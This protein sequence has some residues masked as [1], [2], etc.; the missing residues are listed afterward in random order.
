MNTWGNTGSS[1]PAT[2]DRALWY[3]MGALLT[4]G[5][6][7]ALA[8]IP[9]SA[10]EG[11][12]PVRETAQGSAQ[13]AQ[14][15]EAQRFDIPAGDLQTALL[16]FSQAVDLQLLYP[17]E[18]TAER[19]TQGVQGSYTPEEA[20]SR[21]LAGTGLQ[22]RFSDANTVTLTKPGTQDGAGPL[23]LGPITVEGATESAYGPVDG[24]KASRSATATRTDTPLIDV[25][26]AIQVV[27]RE[28]I[29][30]QKANSLA[31]VA[32]NV[33]NVQ[34]GGTFGNR[35]EVLRIRGFE[36]F[37]FTSDGMTSNP[38]FGDEIFLDLANVERVEVLKGPASVLYGQGGPGGLVN[39]VTKKPLDEPRYAADVTVGSY[40]FVRPTVDVSTPLNASKSL[41]FRVNGAYQ[42]SD[43]FRDY[44]IDSERVFVAPI[45]TWDI[46]P[47][48]RLTLSAQYAEQ[49]N[50]FDRG[51]TAVGDR[52]A[53][54]P[55]S[56]YFGERFSKYEADQTRL[57]YLLEHE[58]NDSWK[59]RNSARF[60]TGNASRFSA[61]NR[62]L[63]ADNRT[64][65]RRTFR[66]HDDIR[67]LRLQNDVIGAFETGL[68][69]HEVLIGVEAARAEREVEYAIA[70]LAPIDIFDPV[71]GAQP[72]T[73]GSSTTT[74]N[75]INNVGLYLQDQVSIG[76]H[77]QVLAGGRFDYADIRSKRNGAV[78]SDQTEREFSP[79]LGLV[80]KPVD[81]VSLYASYS[82]SF[83]PEIGSTYAGSP[84]EPETGEQYE[85]G[86]KTEFFDR[87][88]STTLAAF[89]L[90]RENVLTADPDNPGF[91]VQTG[92]QRSRGVELDITG[93]I[94]P[95]WKVIASGA[96]I[97]AEVTEDNTIE[98]GNRLA[99]VPEISGSL[100]ST[101]E[102]QR[103]SLKGFG[104]GGGLFAV[105]A[106]K[107]DL[108]NT[109]DVDG[110]VRTDAT[111]FYNYSENIQTS[112]NIQN[113]F[114]VEYIEASRG[115]REI[116][117]GAPLT[118]MGT[119]SLTF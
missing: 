81:R 106:R 97:D 9:A 104:F 53:D 68:L 84:F 39:L 49:E 101:Y 5:S 22:Y 93:E 23:Q 45:G 118:V 38:F 20:L 91:S 80:Y 116:H 59:V 21:L 17:A 10:D 85:V 43:S 19:Q 57:R 24:Y 88:V 63:Q 12:Q 25:P 107:G 87:R 112:L 27:P 26:Q 66:Q 90:T 3:R 55:H 28:V 119:L 14:A 18:M 74:D 70:S 114:D 31:D 103:G 48:T 64:L 36:Q 44:F 99:N 13:L 41:K 89:Q 96:Y 109:F 98:V 69:E 16:A 46:S 58:F 40:E 65:D 77:W 35:A 62:G 29:E 7:L 79:R 15:A 82:Q 8:A 95:G 47:D 102:F 51:L 113:L 6:L 75:R 92:E 56:R 71:Y 72:G 73:F 110:Y 4:G 11:A 34:A 1:R 32:K 42:R 52:V 61:D 83:Q 100:W 76:D 105:G 94:L 37:A 50:Q 60:V 67:E 33:S 86:V 117:P 115:R 2:R 54:V 78:T 111:V 108:E 30:D